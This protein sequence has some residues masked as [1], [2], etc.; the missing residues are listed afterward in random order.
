MASLEDAQL[1][2]SMPESTMTLLSCVH[3]ATTRFCTSAT[4]GGACIFS[5]FS[6][7]DVRIPHPPLASVWP[8]YI[9]PM[10]IQCK[11]Q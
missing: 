10:D 3:F 8:N 1:M 11:H 2:G 4:V 7:A 9:K 6:E 5:A